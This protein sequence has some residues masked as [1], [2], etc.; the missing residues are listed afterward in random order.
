MAIDKAGYYR[1][2]SYCQSFLYI[3]VQI[4]NLSMVFE[5]SFKSGP[6]PVHFLFRFQSVTNFLPRQ[7]QDLDLF[8]YRR[9]LVTSFVHDSMSKELKF[10]IFFLTLRLVIDG[11][12]IQR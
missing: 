2:N 12:S 10:R 11:R 9:A 8:I 4:L 7:H 6:E 3:C 5:S 1:V